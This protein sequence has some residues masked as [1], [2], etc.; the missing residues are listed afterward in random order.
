MHCFPLSVFWTFWHYQPYSNSFLGTEDCI[1]H[2][3]VTNNHGYMLPLCAHAI[4]SCWIVQRALT[5]KTPLCLHGPGATCSR[6][7]EHQASW[8]AGAGA[9]VC[10]CAWAKGLHCL[11]S[12]CKMGTFT[13]PF[14]PL[15]SRKQLKKLQT[16]KVFRVKMQGNRE[17]FKNLT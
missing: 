9:S 11:H 16:S 5:N 17:S 12:H 2:L 15:S 13:F 4:S 8:E 1:L 7:Q 14:S 10:N 3:Q 6:C